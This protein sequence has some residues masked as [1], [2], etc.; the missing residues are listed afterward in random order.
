M[1][2]RHRNAR[3]RTGGLLGAAEDTTGRRG[4]SADVELTP[5]DEYWYNVTLL[6]DGSSTTANLK[7]G[8]A[9]VT[10][11]D[12]VAH[13]TDPGSHPYATDFLAFNSTQDMKITNDT[14]V[15]FGNN[16][17]TIE[18]WIYRTSTE[19][20]QALFDGR[21]SGGVG[22]LIYLEDNGGG[23][24]NKLILNLGGDKITGDTTLLV[25]TWYHVALT[26]EDNIAKLFLDGDQEGSNWNSEANSFTPQTALEIGDKSYGA[27]SLNPFGGHMTD[28]RITKGVARYTEAFTPP[29]ASFPTR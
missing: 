2:R 17:F 16:D 27:S 14:Y 29:T 15:A 9:N 25:N 19:F 1:Y 28:I 21:S 6:M 24:P 13:S 11:S 7:S 4:I 22:P 3:L 26:V 10:S 18:T 12:V 23:T 20:G 5:G 8:A